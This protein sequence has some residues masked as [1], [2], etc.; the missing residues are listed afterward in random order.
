MP[1]CVTAHAQW[2]WSSGVRLIFE[3]STQMRLIV[4]DRVEGQY[5]ERNVAQS[6]RFLF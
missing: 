3:R 1:D 2:M 6:S 4:D 5:N